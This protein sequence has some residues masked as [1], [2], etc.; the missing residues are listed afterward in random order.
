MVWV[1]GWGITLPRSLIFSKDYNDY[2]L[3]VAAKGIWN[4]AAYRFE[5]TAVPLAVADDK[6][7]LLACVIFRNYNPIAKTIEF[8]CYAQHKNWLSRKILNEILD[9]PFN[10]LKLN[11]VV[12]KFSENNKLIANIVKRLNATLH[13]LP[14]LE[15]PNQNQYVAI[16]KKSNWQKSELYNERSKGSSTT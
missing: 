4:D 2:F 13:I 9:Y 1:T 3:S 14:E 15:G 6:K 12:A 5:D 7:G 16:L 11:C 8:S 10:E